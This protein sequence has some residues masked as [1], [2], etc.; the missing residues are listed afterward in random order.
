MP[1][2]VDALKDNIRNVIGEIQLH[3]IG[4]QDVLEN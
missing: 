2:T 1:E 4:A 3:T